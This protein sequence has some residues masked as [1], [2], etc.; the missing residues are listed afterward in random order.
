MNFMPEVF[1]LVLFRHE[2]RKQPSPHGMRMM[3]YAVFYNMNYAAH[4]N[5]I[6]LGAGGLFSRM[7]RKPPPEHFRI[8]IATLPID[9]L[10]ILDNQKCGRSENG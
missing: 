9:L 8:I 4:A 3:K 2:W 10:T 6:M 1:L 7:V 5:F